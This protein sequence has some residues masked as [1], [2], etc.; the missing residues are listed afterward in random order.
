M[1]G[2]KKTRFPKE[3][4]FNINYTSEGESYSG[5]FVVRR[6]NV[7]QQMQIEGEKARI[8]QGHYYDPSSPGCGIPPH[9]SVMAD[10][11]AFLRVVV[12]E[13][14]DWW[15]D[16]EVFDMDLL[17]EVYNEAQQVDPFRSPISEE[18]REERRLS[19]GEFGENSNTERRESDAHDRIEEMV[20]TEI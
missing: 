1:S 15:E 11:L 14:P 12:V 9:F 13:S 2:S 18:Q 19:V 6:P 16:D 17:A 5:R 8:L 20:S 3:M 10:T 4:T 7:A